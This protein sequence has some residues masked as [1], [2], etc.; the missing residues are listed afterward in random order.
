MEEKIGEVQDFPHELSIALKHIIA[1]HHGYHEF[2][3]PK[4]PMIL[5]S[6]VLHYVEDLDAKVSSFCGWMDEQV[7]MENPDWTKYWQLYDRYLFRWKGSGAYAGEQD[8]EDEA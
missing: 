4:V 2:G 7:D 8:E 5:E 3:S 1:S 6:L